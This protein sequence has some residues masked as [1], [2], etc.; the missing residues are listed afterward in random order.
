MF[1]YRHAFHAGNHADVLKHSI[2]IH[3]L[4]YF[5][6]KDT[7]FWVIDTH[8]GTGLYN[9]TNKWA[10]TSDES[11]TGLKKLLEQDKQPE[12]ISKYLDL[13]S[14]FNKPKQDLNIYPGSP[15]ISLKIIRPQD[16][17][18]L[19]ELLPAEYQDLSKQCYDNLKADKKQLSIILDDGFKGFAKLLPPQPRRGIIFIDPSYEIKTDY[20]QVIENLKIGLRKYPQGTYII[21]HPLVQR[22]QAHDMVRTLRKM[23]LKWLH[24]TLT[25]KQPAA[26]GLGMHGSGMFI[27]NPPWTL[28]AALESSLPWLTKNLATDKHASYEL[29]SYEP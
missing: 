3:T 9:L 16:K 24:A 22:V 8:A 10:K 2:L 17:L 1:S 27:I 29:K 23:P 11:S 13:I 14:S 5:T 21:W 7:P 25:I 15:A 12:L 4:S 6:Q 26:N 18:F 19:F 28:H 20:Q